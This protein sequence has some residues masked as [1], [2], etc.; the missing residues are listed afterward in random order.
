LPHYDYRGI[1]PTCMVRCT[2]TQLRYNDTAL[3]HYITTT[4][5]DKKRHE[6]KKR[7]FNKG[8]VLALLSVCCLQRRC[9]GVKTRRHQHTRYIVRSIFLA[10][11]ADE[12]CGGPIGRTKGECTHVHLW[13][14]DCLPILMPNCPTVPLSHCPTSLQ[15][16]VAPQSSTDAV[17][18][19]CA[20]SGRRSLLSAFGTD[21]QCQRESA[22]ALILECSSFRH[23]RLCSYVVSCHYR[24]PYCVSKSVPAFAATCLQLL[25]LDSLLP[26]RAKRQTAFGRVRLMS[27]DF[28]WWCSVCAV[29]LSLRLALR[30]ERHVHRW[31]QITVS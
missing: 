23:R 4:A 21:H 27:G 11:L 7:L 28:G 10:V 9:T 15:L 29:S 3:A 18:L 20:W 6:R 2:A 17:Y 14:K 24:C 26:R 1:D 30:T 31:A 16:Q 22:C 19:R 12:L 5:G 13:T 8:P 25:A